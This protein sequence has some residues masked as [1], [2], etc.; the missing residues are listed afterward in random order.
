MVL[1]HIALKSYKIAASK[2]IYDVLMYT[3]VLYVISWTSV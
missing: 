2:W 3:S 1:E